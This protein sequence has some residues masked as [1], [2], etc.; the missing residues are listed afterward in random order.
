MLLATH[1][2]AS[3]VT[4]E[5]A[6]DTASAVA[7]EAES[8]TRAAMRVYDAM[9]AESTDTYVQKEEDDA[10][11]DY[12]EGISAARM[13]GMVSEGSAMRVPIVIDGQMHDIAAYLFADGVSY[14]S[15]REA[16]AL[17][18]P[19]ARVGWDVS[20]GVATL[21]G[22]GLSLSAAW[23]QPYIEVNGRYF[24]LSGL[25]P[26]ENLLVSGVTYVP[27][28]NL[29]RAAGASVTWNAKARCAELRSS[30][31]TVRSGKE[32]YNADDVYWLSKI[33]YAESG[34]QSLRGQLAVGAVILNR[35]AHDAYPDTVYGVIFD[36]KYGVQFTPTVDG[37]IHKTPSEKSIIAAKL[38]LDG[39]MIS[40]SAL[41]FLDPRMASSFWIVENCKYLFTIGCHDFYI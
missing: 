15:L 16:S 27:L 23:G 41:Y 37:A 35:K 2:G 31:S 14:L 7:A 39:C 10:P 19:N 22:D 20:R 33:I 9:E 8:E 40:R 29:A 18:F 38:V 5:N 32:F 36:R 13:R 34:D 28:R 26:A 1:V 24:A 11:I 6:L 12:K 3:T 17:L 30:Q 4:E 21:S 25:Y